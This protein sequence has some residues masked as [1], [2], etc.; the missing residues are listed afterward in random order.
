[1]IL[2]PVQSHDYPAEAGQ[3]KVCDNLGNPYPC[4]GK[5]LDYPNT[6]R[7][8]N[9]IGEPINK[10]WSNDTKKF[11]AIHRPT[12]TFA[13]MNTTAQQLLTRRWWICLRQMQ[14]VERLVCLVGQWLG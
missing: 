10:L 12:P 2:V 14:K 1:M 7:I 11:Y 3:D 5:D 6:R 9:I 4:I 8:I 13:E